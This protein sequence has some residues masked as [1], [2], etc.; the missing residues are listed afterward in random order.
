MTDFM[1]KKTSSKQ[2]MPTEPLRFYYKGKRLSQ[3]RAFVHTVKLGTLT[4]AAEAMFVSQSTVSLM[5]KALERDLGKT[6]LLRTRRRVTLTGAGE[7]LYE[8]ARPLIERMNGIDQDFLARVAGQG[9]STLHIAAGTS[10]LQY[11]LPPLLSRYRERY[12]KVHLNLANVTGRDGLKLLREDKVDFAVGSMLDVPHDL[13]YAPVYHFDPLLIMPLGHPLAAHAN[14]G[15]E[16]LS[17]YGLILPPERLSTYRLVDMVFHQHRIPYT[18]AIEVGGWDVIKAYVASGL[19]ISI[20]TS[21]CLVEADRE[22]LVTRNLKAYFPSRSYGVVMRKGKV[23][24]TEARDFL[25]LIKPGLFSRGGNDGAGHS[26][27]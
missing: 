24:Q 2:L 14:P 6:L 26:E 3:L 5:I 15:L 21:I 16:D 8:L 9:S 19:G 4:R 17:P 13:V 11:L 25:N 22:R 27:R 1:I 10:T 18:V 23:L 12:P 20:V 7:I